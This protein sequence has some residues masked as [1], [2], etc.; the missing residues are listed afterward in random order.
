MDRWLVTLGILVLIGLVVY[1]AIKRKWF[2]RPRG[3]FTGIAVYHEWI[4]RDAQRST[5]MIIRRNAGDQEEEDDS[6]EPD[7]EEF[8]RAQEMDKPSDKDKGIT[9]D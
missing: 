1:I 4:N 5:E 3:A 2:T 9:D 8:L 6:G 7:F